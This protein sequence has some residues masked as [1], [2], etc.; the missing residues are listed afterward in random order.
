MDKPQRHSLKE[1]SAATMH[2]DVGPHAESRCVC[3]GGGIHICSWVKQTLTFLLKNAK[4]SWLNKLE[5]Y[6]GWLR[7]P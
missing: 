7:M 5:K 2:L 6:T 4:S 1:G 3:G